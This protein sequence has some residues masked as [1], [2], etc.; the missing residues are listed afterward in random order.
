M[1]NWMSVL[2]GLNEVDHGTRRHLEM[3]NEMGG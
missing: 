1:E 2:Q 3:W